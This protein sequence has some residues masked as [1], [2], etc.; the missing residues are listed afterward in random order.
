MII[1]PAIGGECVS[2][3][4]HGQPALFIAKRYYVKAARLRRTAAVQLQVLLRCAYD[5]SLFGPGYR[6]GATA[7]AVALAVTNFR[8]Y[9]A[10]TVFHDEVNFAH[11]A[12]EIARQGFQALTMQIV[13]GLAFPPATDSPAIGHHGIGQ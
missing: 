13:F 6:F 2:N 10:L 8:K 5:A 12:I 11:P 4:F 9:Q 3:P 1:S 7:E